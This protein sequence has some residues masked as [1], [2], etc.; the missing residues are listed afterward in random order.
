MPTDNK[1]QT[2]KKYRYINIY[3]ACLI[4]ALSFFIYM[5]ASESKYCFPDANSMYDF[6]F[7]GCISN[8]ISGHASNPRDGMGCSTHSCATP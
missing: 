6:R 5:R 4:C 8:I 3:I 2:K 1:K 7:K